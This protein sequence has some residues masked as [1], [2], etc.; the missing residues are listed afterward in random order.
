MRS[1]SSDSSSDCENSESDSSDSA[2]EDKSNSKSKSS[3]LIYRSEDFLNHPEKISLE[4]EVITD[5][6]R[7]VRKE[8]SMKGCLESSLA[9]EGESLSKDC[10]G[11]VEGSAKMRIWSKTRL[12]IDPSCSKISW[13]HIRKL[14]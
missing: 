1:C 5:L 3:N 6:C 8:R 13:N 4:R 14:L 11:D 7:L 10:G 2:S 9:K 12:I